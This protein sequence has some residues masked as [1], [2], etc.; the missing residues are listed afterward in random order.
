[1]SRQWAV[2]ADDLHAFFHKRV[3]NVRSTSQVAFW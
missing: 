3:L 2:Q 1:V